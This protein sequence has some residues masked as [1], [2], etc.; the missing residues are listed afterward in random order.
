ML[1]AHTADIHLRP[2][3]RQSEYYE[4]LKT[5][6]ED[7]KAQKVDHIFVGGDI[8]HLKTSGISPEYINILTWWLNEMSK[9]AHV[10]LV[11]GNHDLNL[12]NLS[13][14]DAVSP[15]VDAMNNPRVHLYK[16][17]GVYQFSP[18][19]NFCV[20]S[21][22]DEAGWANVKPVPGDVNIATFHGGVKGS[23]TETG[24]EIEEEI[25][26]SD[27]FKDYDFCLLGDIHKQQFLGYRDGKPWIGYSGTPIQQNYAEQI[28][29]GYLLWD[30]KSS[31]SWTVVNRPLPN[32][33]PFITL[34][35]AENLNKTIDLAKQCPKG[36]RFR[37]RSTSQLTQDD[38]HVLNETLKTKF[39]A[40]EVIFKSDFHVDTSTIKTNKTSI[41][42]TDLRSHETITKLLKDYYKDLKLSDSDFE[43]IT[44]TAKNYLK[45]VSSIEDVSRSSKWSLRKLEWDNTFAYGENNVVNFE[46]LNGIVGIF[47]PNRTGKSS[48]VGT[49]MYAL[50]NSSDR[51]ALKNINICNT[52]KEYCSA[53]V[54]LD[55][56]GST[57]VIE[58]Q[59][60]K[61]S[62]KKGVVSATTNLNLFKMNDNGNDLDDLCGEQR[63]DTEKTLRLLLGHPDDFLLTS[64]SSQGE[65]NQFLSQGSS[66][67]RSILTKFL[68]L[69]IFDKMNEIASKEVSSIKSQL[70]NFPDRNWD[71]L[72]N[73]YENDL[74]ENKQKIQILTD[75][76]FES[77]TSLALLK[78]DL[79]CHNA[80]PITQDDI[81]MQER[82][83]KDLEK[84]SDDCTNKIFILEKETEDLQKKL[85]SI[86]SLITTLG[87]DDLLEKQETQRKLQNTIIELRHIYEKENSMLEQQ[88]RSLKILDEVPC[89][90]DYPTCKF[91]KDAHT[92]KNLFTDQLGKVNK[93]LLLLD[94]AKN[95]LL[96]IQDVTVTENIE[97][98]NKASDL[99]TKIILEISK[100]EN[101]V[102]RTKSSCDTCSTTLIEAKKKL[103]NLKESLK[104][105]ENEEI[106]SIRSKILELTNLT[107]D[108]DTKKLE[109]ASQIGKIQSAIDKLFEEKLIRDNLLQGIRTH[110]LVSNAFSKKG[111]PLLVT[112]TQ[113]PIINA[114]VSKILQGIVDFTIEVESDEDTDTLE[115]YINYGDSRR[116]IELC[117]G[118]EKTISAIAIRVAMINISSLPK[119]DFFIIDEGFGTLDNTGI[120]SC[121]R[122][123]SSLKCYFKTIIVIT[124]VDGIKDSTDHVLEI[125]KNEKDSKVEFN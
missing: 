48:I 1:I 109:S 72:K 46:K 93:S 117:S 118:M 82:K 62:N 70:K 91:I 105:D 68:D 86:Q 115:I 24:W 107:K 23:V 17:S 32:T 65:I 49:L 94:Q 92:N 28:D 97:K 96:K 79:S 55:H 56:N 88:K 95:L 45:Q 89:G 60:A 39:F 11:L 112:K 80:S 74:D 51:G 13:R 67:R 29:H 37:I 59:T 122:L 9:V 6:I 27:F 30:I 116:I 20:F 21:I 50:F 125:T 41:V 58:R 18:G 83:V 64:L 15:I 38:I 14:Q 124:H 104:N 84:K 78:S 42:K 63:T 26:S 3:S 36:T 57:Y 19:Y 90:D 22:C 40:T 75:Q 120:E 102:I 61:S 33:K 71:N 76:I 47:G 34:D 44:E 12:S 66:K 4:I 111:I 100:K 31:S 52:R 35:W 54:V 101:E 85:N 69:D 43:K 16:N 103:V 99:N 119:S 114:E 10:H 106:V 5:F 123:L 121:S 81:D 77:Q 2:S 87:I 108:C 7:C 73:Q 113:L 53:K 8:Y 25:I 110:E 98:Y